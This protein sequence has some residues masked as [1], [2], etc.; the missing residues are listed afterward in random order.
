[1]SRNPVRDLDAN[2]L[3]GSPDS[4]EVVAML[5]EGVEV[6]EHCILSVLSPATVESVN[7][8]VVGPQ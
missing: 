6:V 1:V 5:V 8:E 7:P 2:G 3:L 4:F